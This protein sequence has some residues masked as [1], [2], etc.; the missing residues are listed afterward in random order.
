[1][2]RN[3]KSKSDRFKWNTE[4]LERAADYFKFGG[5]SV[6]EAAHKYDIPK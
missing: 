1:M 6:R 3:Y 2:V 4:N 5:V